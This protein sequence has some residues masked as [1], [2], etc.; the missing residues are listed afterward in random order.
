MLVAF[1]TIVLGLFWCLVFEIP[2]IAVVLVALVVATVFILLLMA[3][4]KNID[5]VATAT[6]TERVAVYKEIAKRSGFSLGWSGPSRTYYRYQDVLDHYDCVFSVVY[7]S[8]RTG[9]IRCEEGG[10][11]YNELMKKVK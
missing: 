11:T 6:L 5:N 2:M 3:Y 1:L 9:V 4:K 10:A 8:G 7:K